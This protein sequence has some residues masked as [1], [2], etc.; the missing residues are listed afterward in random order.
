MDQVPDIINLKLREEYVQIQRK[1][2]EEL[3]NCD[4]FLKNIIKYPPSKKDGIYEIWEDKKT[5]M[6]IFDSLRFNSLIIYPNVSIDY[7]LLLCDKWTVPEELIE[8]L[9]E[10][11]LE[12]TETPQ[13]RNINIWDCIHLRCVNCKLGFNVIENKSDSCKFHSETFTHQF[14]TWT[15]CNTNNEYCKVGY[16]T[17]SNGLYDVPNLIDSIKSM[18]KGEIE[19][20]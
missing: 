18:M 6:S 17:A 19:E 8:K 5:V 3:G 11:Q 2:L 10:K 4:W 15:C 13:K 1:E 14:N 12:L 9:N 7:M 16:H 20:K